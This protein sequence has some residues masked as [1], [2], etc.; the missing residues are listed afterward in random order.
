M[1]GEEPPFQKVVA[2]PRSGGGGIDDMSQQEHRIAICD[3]V[4]PNL[5]GRDRKVYMSALSQIF[6]QYSRNI[7]KCKVSVQQPGAVVVKGSISKKDAQLKLA[8]LAS[9]QWVKLTERQCYAFMNQQN[10]VEFTQ[11]TGAYGICRPKCE[12]VL[13]VGP[14]EHLQKA[15]HYI[16]THYGTD[17]E[18]GEG[19]RPGHTDRRIMK[20]NVLAR[21]H[22]LDHRSQLIAK[23]EGHIWIDRESE[24]DGMQDLHI[25]GYPRNFNFDE[26]ERAIREVEQSYLQRIQPSFPAKPP[27]VGSVLLGPSV[28]VRK[29]R[30][31][32]KLLIAEPVPKPAPPPSSTPSASAAPG[33]EKKREPPWAEK[34]VSS[35]ADF[36]VLTNPL[37]YSS[38]IFTRSG[39]RDPN[40]IWAMNCN[41]PSNV[42]TNSSTFIPYPSSA[43]SQ[44][45]QDQDTEGEGMAELSVN[46]LT[47]L[48][49]NDSPPTS[50]RLKSLSAGQ[51]VQQL[52]TVTKGVGGS[53]LSD[54]EKDML[55]DICLTA[56][57][58]PVRQEEVEKPERKKEKTRRQGKE[59]GRVDPEKDA[60]KGEEKVKVLVQ[61]KGDVEAL[62]G[63][64]TV[65]LA[66]KDPFSKLRKA[67]MQQL[68][69]G[70][71]KRYVFERLDPDFNEWVLIH[72]TELLPPL[73]RLTMRMP[74][75]RP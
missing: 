38:T 29:H 3:F 75:N 57:V 59:K 50:P 65:M 17:Q 9:S 46:W 18:G 56:G 61:Y 63:N 42:S 67:I 73:S 13:V 19:H 6:R 5:Q 1:S 26:A 51:L 31:S 22:V 39:L 41:D 53:A 37:T 60:D 66:A 47:D 21:Q 49:D 68:G 44:S 32:N 48:E 11:Q 64:H 54:T 34:R 28:Q 69:L 15:L 62:H 24:K 58:M 16:E 2:R 12:M 52:H 30:D 8:K 55:K 20:I 70:Q 36:P 43:S 27:Q 72:D 10:L 4:P 14:P 7:P 33:A 71:E 74:G 40:N 35:A 25:V 45:G 23:S